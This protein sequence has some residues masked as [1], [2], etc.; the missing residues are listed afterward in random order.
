MGNFN[1][2]DY[3]NVRRKFVWWDKLKSIIMESFLYGI[4]GKVVKGIIIIDKV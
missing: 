3:D 1:I 4:D 2:L